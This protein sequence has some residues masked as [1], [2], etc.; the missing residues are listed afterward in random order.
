[1]K[2]ERKRQGQGG[3]SLI[4]LMVV[5]AIMGLLMAVVGAAFLGRL[6]KGKQAAAKNQIKAFED[7]LEMYYTDVYDYPSSL[8]GLISAEGSADGWYGP[9]LKKAKEIPKD[10]WGNDYVYQKGGG[11]GVEFTIISYGKDGAPGGDNE[12]ADV[13]NY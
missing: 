4:E 3:F 1:M 12:N 10:P 8:N 2:K 13:T 6:G 7:A 5:I 9:Y 11:E